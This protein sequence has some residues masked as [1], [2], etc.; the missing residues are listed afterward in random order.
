MHL[1]WAVSVGSVN[2]HLYV[3]LYFEGV[4]SASHFPGS[5]EE[6]KYMQHFQGQK[7]LKSIMNI[8]YDPSLLP[9]TQASAHTR[10]NYFNQDI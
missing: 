4:S 6:K 10:G 9:C 3:P 7:A 1:S 8:H 5:T 2:G